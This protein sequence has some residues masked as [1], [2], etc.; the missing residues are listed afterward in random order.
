MYLVEL[1]FVLLGVFLLAFHKKGVYKIPL[2]WLVIAPTA[3]AAAV[4]VNNLQRAMVMFPMVEM[5][6]AY[7]LVHLFTKVKGKKKAI[8]IAI[9]VS[10]FLLNISYFLHQY[11]V[12]ARVHRSWYRNNGFSQMMEL[13]NK[14]YN[15]YDLIITTKS[16]GGY[17]LFQFYSKYNPLKYQLEGSP[18]DKNY[19]GFGKF[20][21]T[22]DICPFISKD[23]LIPRK[24]KIIFIEDGRCAENKNLYK[25]HFTYIYREDKTKAF[26][27]VYVQNDQIF[28]TK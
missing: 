28:K 22:P 2:I 4:D 15:N 12:I 7:G 11:F 6:A 23:P 10:L 13:V 27:V 1:P 24:G 16:G 17:P 26:R 3:A 21:F 25:V 14:D 19:T 8:L 9:V 20:I 5:T 18:K